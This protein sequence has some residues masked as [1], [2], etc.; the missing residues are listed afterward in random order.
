[1]ENVPHK[2]ICSGK[3]L[4]VKLVNAHCL[5]LSS[6]HYLESG[7][8]STEKEVFVYQHGGEICT[9]KSSLPLKSREVL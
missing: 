4:C 6:H 3:I 5:A 7:I 2:L 8:E 9:L 1:M